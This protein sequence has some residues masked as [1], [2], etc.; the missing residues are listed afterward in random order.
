M[1]KERCYIK[2]TITHYI[3]RSTFDDKIVKKFKQLQQA[4]NYVLWSN[5]APELDQ[6]TFCLVKHLSDN[7]INFPPNFKPTNIQILPRIIFLQP[8][9]SGVD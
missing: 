1:P 7:Q 2:Q 6:I 5:N 8:P 4:I 3:V 9:D